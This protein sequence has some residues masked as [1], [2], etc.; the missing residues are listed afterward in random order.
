MR[1][2]TF[3]VLIA[4]SAG[5]GGGDLDIATGD[6]E[7]TFSEA[8]LLG[9]DGK[10]AADRG[11]NVVLREIGRRP[12]NTGGYET[13]CTA[14]GGCFYVW[15][16]T[17]D[18][19]AQAVAE[20]AKPYVLYQSGSSP[21]WI[22]VTPSA[23]AGAP[24]GF[25]RYTFK[26]KKGTV[27]AGASTTSLMN[28]RIQVSPFLRTATRARLFDH[29][30]VAGD[31]DVYALSSA[32][33]W[34]VRNDPAV[35]PPPAPPV[36]NRA[37]VQFLGG[38][39]QAQHGALVGGGK[40]VVEYDLG[41]LPDCRG[42][43]N[44]YPAWDTRAFVRFSPGGQLVDGTVR[45]FDTTGGTPHG[46]G[47]PV[48]F[49][50]AIPAGATRAE[51]WFQNFTGAGSSCVG[52]DSNNGQNYGFEVVAAPPAVGWAGGL[53]GSFSR[54]CEHQAGLAEPTLLGSYE[55][56]R[57]CM[58]VDADVWVPGLTDAAA[59]HP[60]RLLAQAEVSVDGKPASYVW[61]SYVGRVGNDY[62]FRWDVPREELGRE[63]WNTVRYSLRFSTDGASWTRVG[64][65]T[66]E[67]DVSWCSSSWASCAR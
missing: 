53:G 41:R 26:L 2:A 43:H 45:G 29:N 1:T 21:S 13:A 19:S 4:L 44:G 35:C 6:D 66:L 63:F 47:L 46:D 17:L 10:D 20:G 56:E 54:A 9:A 12:N 24:Q 27:S 25:K 28:T 62:R 23:A 15:G 67:R 33:G 8:P 52:W 18:V 34:S 22:Q 60:E 40:L 42:T 48:P 58:F 32:N 65:R 59:P 57:A 16:G 50:T 51:V 39:R 64:P 49:E 11:C 14:S 61:L 37:T 3:I 55:R 38:W 30:R 36:A 31:F 5:C 7:E